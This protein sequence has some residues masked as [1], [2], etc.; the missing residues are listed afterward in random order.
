MSRTPNWDLR[1]LPPPSL[2]AR[3]L[4]PGEPSTPEQAAL[5][6]LD[7][8]AA[9]IFALTVRSAADFRLLPVLPV[10]Q[11]PELAAA[12][13]DQGEVA[14]SL[15]ESLAPLLAPRLA[16]L[17]HRLRR[18]LGRLRIEV[19]LAAVREMDPVC[20]RHNTRR[21]G[22]TL[23]EKAGTKQTLRAV[24]RVERFDTME[25]RVLVAA[26]RAITRQI[27]ERLAPLSADARRMQPRARSLRRL[28]NA[29]KTLLSLPEL[30]TVTLPRP[31]ERPSYAL[32]KDTDYRAVYRALRLLRAEEERFVEE[33]QALPQVWA[34]LLLLSVWAVMDAALPDAAVPSWVRPLERRPDTGRLTGSAVRRWLRLEKDCVE[35]WQVVPATDGVEIIHRLWSERD[36][37]EERL[38][39]AWPLGTAPADR[40][41][42]QRIE[43][44]LAKVGVPRG[45]STLSVGMATSI[46]ADDIA[47]SAMNPESLQQSEAGCRFL[48]TTAVATLETEQGEQNLPALGRSAA[49]LKSG[50]LGPHTLHREQAELLGRFLQNRISADQDPK[51]LAI[52]VPDNMSELARRA[53][54]QTLGPCWAVW[55][56]V[57]IA[58]AYAGQRPESALDASDQ[59]EHRILVIGL[60]AASCDLAVLG[61]AG[62]DAQSR[63]LIRRP[64]LSISLPGIES[65]LL[66]AVSPSEREALR[67]AWLREPRN[68]QV[69]I[70]QPTE[71]VSY[72]QQSVPDVRELLCNE[73]AS[74]IQK[75]LKRS[76]SV[77][78]TVLAGVPSTV[79]QELGTSLPHGPRINLPDSA[80]VAGARQFLLRHGGGLPTWEDELLPLY[81]RVREQGRRR[82]DVEL[83]PAGRRIRPGEQLKLLAEDEF[84]IPP[85]VP[86]FDVPLVQG[87]GGATSFL[88]HYAGRPLPLRKPVLVQILIDYRYG[89]DGLRGEL[90][91]LDAAPFARI[92]FDLKSPDETEAEVVSQPVHIPRYV[93]P[94]PPTDSQVQEIRSSIAEARAFLKGLPAQQRRDAKKNP[95]LLAMDLRRLI[96]RIDESLKVMNA[97]GPDSMPASLRSQL[98]DETGPFLEWLAGMARSQDKDGE[99]PALAGQD[100]KRVLMARARTRIRCTRNGD[101]F[102]SAL[103]TSLQDPGRRADSLRAIGNVIDGT[104]DSPWEALVTCDTRENA[105][106]FRG[107]AWGI[108]RALIAHPDLATRLSLEQAEQTL[109]VLVEGLCTLPAGNAKMKSHFAIALQAIPHLCRV[110]QAGH[111]M[112]PAA[113]VQSAIHNLASLRTRMAEEILRHAEGGGAQDEPLSQAIEAL[114]GREVHLIFVE[115]DAT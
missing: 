52:V 56:T 50:V 73:L 1:G 62:Q 97:S 17:R 57:A 75:L 33:W 11:A 71:P 93:S 7:S 94:L 115:K 70:E 68:P 108:R 14:P 77:D 12:L 76:G 65:L 25:N 88:L 4:L 66:D 43:Q 103:L 113:S 96:G 110:R 13:L 39:I 63:L 21:P 85:D 61:W 22:K 41:I 86:T 87:G 109:R 40:R 102:S 29:A 92:P 78:L 79:E 23:V 26:C 10:A 3:R 2:A 32:L 82:R 15:L 80:A 74:A 47:L 8:H 6:L 19:P 111:L 45:L 58:L 18:R 28:A 98:T 91:A 67:A 106:H 112:P 100:E 83:I 81:A 105:E 72:R 44:Q 46:K 49:F 104:P 54:R 42:S 34:E 48:D 64:Q 53:L 5:H 55:H 30:S 36:T 24:V 95:S 20:L 35:E 107:Q 69:W 114:E 51:R 59:Q 31:G 27:S 84:T 89:F 60:S 37:D 90:R 99:A 101:R 16:R 9:A 38:A